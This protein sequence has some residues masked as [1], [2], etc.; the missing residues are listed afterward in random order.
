MNILTEIK[1]AQATLDALIA[2]AIVI[3]I[4]IEDGDYSQE[5][6]G[7]VVVDYE[8]HQDYEGE[9]MESDCSMTYTVAFATKEE[10]LAAEKRYCKFA[11][12]IK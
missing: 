3:E 4:H 8:F 10:A 11:S 12:S 5:F 9:S 6:E 7:G 1:K 2:K